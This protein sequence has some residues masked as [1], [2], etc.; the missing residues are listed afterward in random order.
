MTQNSTPVN[1][2]LQVTELCHSIWYLTL[3]SL[4][5]CNPSPSTR[6][7]TFTPPAPCSPSKRSCWS[8]CE[9]RSLSP[10]PSMTCSESDNKSRSCPLIDNPQSHLLCFQCSQLWVLS[11]WEEKVSKKSSSEGQM[12]IKRS[13]SV[14]LVLGSFTYLAPH[15]PPPW[16][17]Y[18]VVAW[19]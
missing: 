15:A 4:F 3:C 17:H 2:R 18:A 16:R 13:S 9:D 19:W 5:L 1:G 14:D 10:P 8:S 7:V 12:T 11:P 6:R